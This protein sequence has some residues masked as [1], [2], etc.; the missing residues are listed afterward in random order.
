VIK[1]VLPLILL[2]LLLGAQKEDSLL[3]YLNKAGIK[4]L[5]K[6]PGVDKRLAERII[7][8]RKEF[9]G[10]KRREEL[11][12]I[13]GIGKKKLTL[14]EYYIKGWKININTAPLKLLLFLPHV[15]EKTAKRIIAYREKRR[16]NSAQ[17]LLKI[18]G[19][20]K[21]KVKDILLFIKF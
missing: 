16:I 20:G 9:S 10:Y 3:L 4:E 2:P 5:Q 15:G 18:K 1:K 11:L 12:S 14:M 17:D 7:E 13:K 6:L 19:L 21:K 8:K